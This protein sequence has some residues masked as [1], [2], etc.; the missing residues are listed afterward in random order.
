MHSVTVS[1]DVSSVSYSDDGTVVWAAAPHRG[2]PLRTIV[3][4]DPSAGTVRTLL[5]TRPGTQ[6]DLPQRSHGWLVWVEATGDGSSD[7]S[8]ISWEVRALPYGST[9]TISLARS[10]K[11]GSVFDVPLPSFDFPWV[12]WT[13]TLPRVPGQLP[14]TRLMA[15]DLR[16]RTLRELSRI[17]N[18]ATVIT[19]AA[20]IIYDANSAGG[21]RDVFEYH[22]DTGSVEQLTRSGKVSYPAAS[23]HLVGWQEPATGQ[24]QSLWACTPRCTMAGAAPVRIADLTEGNLA[25]GDSVV[26]YGANDHLYIV[27]D[28]LGTPQ[29]VEG[30]KPYVE[31]RWSLRGD[32]V[33]LAEDPGGSSDRLEVVIDQL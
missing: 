13:E 25:V 28:P 4:W 29:T 19:R 32:E 15:V 24:P 31:A 10:A 6:V 9:Q 20:V 26:V 7:T 23:D 11:P 1:G 8:G 3:Q 17:G 14:G 12:A 33:A 2:D 16:T 27:H 30:P 18:P 5:Q 21:G 22:L